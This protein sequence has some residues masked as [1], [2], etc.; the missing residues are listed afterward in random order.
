LTT[1]N[2]YYPCFGRN[3][4]NRTDLLHG[5]GIR[6]DLRDCVRCCYGISD[7]LDFRYCICLSARPHNCNWDIVR[8]SLGL[9]MAFLAFQRDLPNLGLRF[10]NRANDRDRPSDRD[11]LRLRDILL[12]FDNNRYRFDFGELAFPFECMP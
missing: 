9:A 11:A 6:F 1:C 8:D 3:L 4:C 2:W 12:L 5:E 7:R 10:R